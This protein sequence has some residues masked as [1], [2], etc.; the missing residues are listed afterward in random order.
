MNEP[1]TGDQP[2]L[3]RRKNDPTSAPEIDL[4]RA[5]IARVYDMFFEE[6][7]D[8]F[9]VDRVVYEQVRQ[10]APDGPLVAVMI[11]RWLDRA[12]GYLVSRAGINQIID[13][14][15]GLPRSAPHE[16]THQI[17]QRSNPEAMVVYV[18]NDPSVAAFGRALLEDNVYT[19][20]VQQD[21]VHPQVVLQDPAVQQHIDFDRP[22]TLV[23]SATLHHVDD[24]QDPVRI[25][26]QYVEVLPPGSYV[27][28]CHWWD[29]DDELPEGHEL[30]RSL[31]NAWRTSSMGTGRY[32]SRGE[33]EAMFCGLPL[34]S[35]GL[36][37][38]DQWWPPGPE[39]TPPTLI[40][41]LMLG[42]VARVP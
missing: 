36:V 7:K 34:L 20:F 8:G 40:E 11:R 31:E 16:N 35:P 9:A 24:D 1:T 37:E 29:P 10:I 4:G 38:L 28:L 22:I 17:A 15:S 39:V 6:G 25:M 41:R 23:Q 3:F 18:D 42:G 14:G 12:I 2:E 19:H 32:R 5:S 13:I 27:V 30:A 33:I 21:L 26:R